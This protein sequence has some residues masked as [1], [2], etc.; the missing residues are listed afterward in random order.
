MGINLFD[1]ELG[2]HTRSKKCY[3]LGVGVWTPRIE[4]ILKHEAKGVAPS[5][6]ERVWGRP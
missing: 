4:F 6:R 2:D 3:F 1:L 5:G